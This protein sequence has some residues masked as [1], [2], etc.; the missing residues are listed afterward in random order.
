VGARARHR[1]RLYLHLESFVRTF[2]PPGGGR[3]FTGAAVV[4]S[5]D[6][7]V[8]RRLGMIAGVERALDRLT[9]DRFPLEVF[10]TAVREGDGVTDL[11]VAGWEQPVAALARD[12]Q[13]VTPAL[14]A[15]FDAAAVS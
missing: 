10:D 11:V 7:R 14:A 13:P 5:H 12:L 1:D 4:D 2:P 15:V 9:H 3:W 8:H 6:F